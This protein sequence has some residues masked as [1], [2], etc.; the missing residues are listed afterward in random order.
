[1]EDVVEAAAGGEAVI[2][3][4]PLQASDGQEHSDGRAESKEG[5]GAEA[6]LRVINRD[7]WEI[8]EGH[9]EGGGQV[10]AYPVYRTVCVH[11]LLLL[12]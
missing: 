4:D 6:E 11:L 12:N 8:S 10:R 3:V 5:L 7:L 2:G 9:L 1:M